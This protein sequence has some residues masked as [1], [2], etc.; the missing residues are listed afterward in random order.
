MGN[1]V[2]IMYVT[3]PYMGVLHIN[4]AQWLNST[5][6]CNALCGSASPEVTLTGPELGQTSYVFA[7]FGEDLHLRA[8]AKVGDLVLVMKRTCKRWPKS[9]PYAELGVEVFRILKGS[10]LVPLRLPLQSLSK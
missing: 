3:V 1:G 5:R 2:R 8:L 6:F 4:P 10:S 7:S 9:T